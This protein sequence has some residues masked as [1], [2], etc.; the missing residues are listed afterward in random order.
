MTLE[1]VTYPTG[2]VMTESD[3]DAYLRDR[4]EV[5]MTD[6]EAREF[7]TAWMQAPY[8]LAGY[9]RTASEVPKLVSDM[10]ETL[11]GSR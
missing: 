9:T 4:R 5:G 3:L 6:A 10:V 1:R 2:W 8:P 7:R 11:R